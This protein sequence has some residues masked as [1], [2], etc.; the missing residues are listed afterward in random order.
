MERVVGRETERD[1]AATFLAAAASIPAV[2]TLEGEAGIG[3]TTLVRY[4]VRLAREAGSQ[5]LH[6]RPTDAES[7]LSFAGLTDLLAG[8]AD[9]VFDG[10]PSPQGR[11]LAVAVLRQEPTG[12]APDARAIGT[13]LG[14]ALTGLATARPLLVV[15]DDAQWLDRPSL[16]ALTFALRRV[17]GV[18]VGVLVSRRTGTAG[19]AD[20]AAAL[21]DPG[22]RQTLNLAGLGSA[23]L[24]HVVRDELGLPLSHPS[25]VRIAESSQG[26]PYI[27]I[28]LA[29]V[30]ARAGSG[31]AA[32]RP[33]PDSLHAL[34]ADR[35][36][37]L[38][39]A[40][41]EAVLAVACSARPTLTLID[42]LGVRSGL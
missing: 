21:P 34:T 36:G 42:G 37:G 26:N 23:A 32:D 16:Q 33:L 7:A 14:T 25:L 29:R 30:A 40:A 38:S 18:P 2:L 1:V 4:V 39:P 31:T 17:R 11:A 10:L 41:A 15:V 8:V 19:A 28:E 9:D 6:C 12:A 3:K 20:L 35:L 27:A 5:V 24:F 22:W 13:G